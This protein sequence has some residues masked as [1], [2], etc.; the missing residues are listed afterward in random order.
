MKYETHGPSSPVWSVGNNQ[1]T[2]AA[3]TIMSQQQQQRRTSHLPSPLDVISNRAE[4]KQLFW[5]NL[6]D[7]QAFRHE[8][9]ILCQ[10]MRNEGRDDQ[11]NKDL[12]RFVTQTVKL[13]LDNDTDDDDDSSVSYTRGLELYSCLERR[14]RRHLAKRYILRAASEL[15]TSS[16]ACCQAEKLANVSRTLSG[17]AST[18]AIEEANRDY[19]QAWQ[20]RKR[21]NHNPTEKETEGS[22]TERNVRS[23]T[24]VE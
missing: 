1:R 18:L 19:Y 9:R 2:T 7:I 4:A 21:P 14:R 6:S 15:S 17:W 24:M 5:Y 20:H 12:L 16:S 3:T 23:R 10:H 13:P 11:N 8:A 22:N